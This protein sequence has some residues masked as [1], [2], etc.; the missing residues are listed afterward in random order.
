MIGKRIKHALG[1]RTQKWL[2]ETIGT[3]EATICRYVKGERVPNAYVLGAIAKALGV[4][5]DWLV[6]LEE[7]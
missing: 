1:N 5:C 4:S 6:G 3:A 2:A 7:N